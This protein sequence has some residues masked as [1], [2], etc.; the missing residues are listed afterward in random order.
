MH[1]TATPTDIGP[2][3]VEA[4]PE[5]DPIP[6]VPGSSTPRQAHNGQVSSNS[7]TSD[8]ADSDKKKSSV[9]AEEVS[10]G[11]EVSGLDETNA[12]V[13]VLDTVYRRV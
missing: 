12:K 1:C 5:P 2:N 8:I 4:S 7:S 13:R 6:G 3:P 11:S 9:S 10:I